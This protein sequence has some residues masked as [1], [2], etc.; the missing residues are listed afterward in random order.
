[1][2]N[3]NCYWNSKEKILTEVEMDRIPLMDKVGLKHCF[4]CNSAKYFA[5]DCSSSRNDINSKIMYCFSAKSALRNHLG[6]SPNELVFD[7][8]IN[9]PSVLTDHLLTM[10][11]ITTSEIV[12]TNLNALHAIRKSFIEAE[13]SGKIRRV[14]RSNIRIYANEEFVTGKAVYYRRQNCKR[15]HG[16]ARVLG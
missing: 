5:C 6:H 11:A 12:R 15:W 8:N 9:T 2:M 3:F 10:E 16:P 14:L 1:M 7:F 4:K 13:S